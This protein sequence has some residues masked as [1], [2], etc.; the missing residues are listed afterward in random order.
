MIYQQNEWQLVSVLE[1]KLII[2]QEIERFMSYFVYNKYRD[3]N[4]LYEFI[5]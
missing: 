1:L 4:Y 2:N 5:Y 3:L